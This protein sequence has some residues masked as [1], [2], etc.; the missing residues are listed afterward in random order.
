M[1]TREFFLA[2][3]LVIY[4][5]CAV[6]VVFFDILKMDSMP[7]KNPFLVLLYINKTVFYDFCDKRST[8]VIWAFLG[9]CKVV[10]K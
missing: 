6:V 4:S 8:V 1:L 5:Y 2:K 7:P 9:S 10:K 3:I